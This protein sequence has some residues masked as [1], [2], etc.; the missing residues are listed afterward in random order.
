M[1]ACRGLPSLRKQIV[2]K[3]VRRALGAASHGWFR[4]VHFSVQ[5]DHVH[6]VVEAH[7]KEALTR[8]MA[9]LAIRVARAVNRRVR[10]RGHVWSDR[11]HARPLR[12]PR[13]VRRAIVY[14]L[15]N[16]RKHVP[17]ARDIDPCSSSR[18][19]DGW[20]HP[21]FS[22]P[23]GGDI[24]VVR[25]RTWLGHTG[26]RRWGLVLVTERPKPSPDRVHEWID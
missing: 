5:A 21:P 10:R 13:E 16:W 15:T 3:D 14:V 11:Y 6:L 24:P 9:G 18:W 20:K 26:W 4:L 12:T 25:A 19:F 22:N 7:D 2:F 23:P 1:R 8:G 17:T